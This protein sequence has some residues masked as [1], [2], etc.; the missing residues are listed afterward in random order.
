MAFVYNA[1]SSFTEI[2]GICVYKM[3]I[4]AGMDSYFFY[5][6]PVLKTKWE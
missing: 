4:L 1:G 2:Q 5:P 6:L 3:N